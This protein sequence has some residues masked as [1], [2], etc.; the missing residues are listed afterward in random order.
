MKFF[1]VSIFL[2]MKF[3]KQIFYPSSVV[4]IVKNVELGELNIFCLQGKFDYHKNTQVNNRNSKERHHVMKSVELG[5]L[6][7]Y[8]YACACAY[9]CSY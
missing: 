2:L 8:V 4:L 1:S 9:T 3:K 7:I 6:Y 5:N